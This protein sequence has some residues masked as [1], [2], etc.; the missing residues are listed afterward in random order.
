MQ[1][2]ITPFLVNMFWSQVDVDGDCWVW[3]G[4]RLKGYGR[5]TVWNG[6]KT[7]WIRAHRMAWMIEHGEDPG[8]LYVCHDC[9][10]PPCVRPSHLFLGTPTVNN[11]DAIRKGRSSRFPRNQILIPRPRGI[12]RVK[13]NLEKAEE[14]RGL[15]RDGDVTYSELARQFNVSRGTI[16]MILAGKIW[17]HD[18][19]HQGAP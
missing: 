15:Y 12:E 1:I 6:E 19:P 9:D 13:L 2:E 16:A 5:F 18:S 8:P 14:I 10:N 7:L 4:Q 17:K 3:M 11:G